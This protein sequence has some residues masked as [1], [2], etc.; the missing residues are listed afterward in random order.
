MQLQNQCSG[1]I[2]KTCCRPFAPLT[3][4]AELI[5]WIFAYFSDISVVLIELLTPV[6]LFVIIKENKLSSVINI[7]YPNV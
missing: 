2:W 3:S 4:L 5:V 1:K 6:L 7:F